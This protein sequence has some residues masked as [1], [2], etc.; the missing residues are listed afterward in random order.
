M[1]IDSSL[2]ALYSECSNYIRAEKI[3]IV[4]TDESEYQASLMAKFER[5][6]AI[7]D[8]A[9]SLSV[10]DKVA[11]FKNGDWMGD[12]IEEIQI[13]SEDGSL[14]AKFVMPASGHDIRAEAPGKAHHIGA[15]Y[16]VKN[17]E[18]RLEQTIRHIRNATSK[19]NSANRK[20]QTNSVP[21][22]G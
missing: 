16:F 22:L 13:S 3:D 9:D 19:R 2:S 11:L 12:E 5:A 4:H 7:V 20:R 14:R 8:K 18:Q 6:C 17:P 10:I 1:R 15:Q 21:Q